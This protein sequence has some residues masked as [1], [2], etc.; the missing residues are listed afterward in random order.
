MARRIVWPKERV[1]KAF[2]DFYRDH[3]RAPRYK[4]FAGAASELGLPSIKTLDNL[5]GKPSLPAAIEDAGLPVHYK[6][7]QRW[8]QDEIVEA[9]K[10]FKRKHGRQPMWIDGDRDFRDELPS[11]QVVTHRFG[12]WNTAIEAAGMTARRTGR[13]PGMANTARVFDVNE[14]A[15]GIDLTAYDFHLLV[16]RLISRMRCD[17]LDA[18]DALQQA[19]IRLA[20]KTDLD[21]GDV[22]GWLFTA[23]RFVLREEFAR[24][25]RHARISFE[26]LFEDGNWEP[27]CPTDLVA[28]VDARLQL[29]ELIE[30]CK[31]GDDVL[32]VVDQDREALNLYE[33][34]AQRRDDGDWLS[35]LPAGRWRE[36]LYQVIDDGQ[37]ACV[38]WEHVREAG[39]TP[40]PEL[41]QYF[42]DCMGERPGILHRR[43][44]STSP[45]LETIFGALDAMAA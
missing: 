25:D 38:C 18:E 1:R 14:V 36:K 9:F 30:R 16:K 43:S 35:K 44:E 27:A 17:R 45:A 23:A 11:G 32:H 3:R 5:Y 33:P 12:S 26:R 37:I 2:A 22:R 28:Q 13:K 39:I 20:A 8:S 19:W 29:A 6:L 34:I 7:S 10:A 24:R 21:P 42:P 4:D 31:P 40:P 15:A 41:A